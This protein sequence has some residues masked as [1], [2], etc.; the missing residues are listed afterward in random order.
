MEKF[1]FSIAPFYYMKRHPQQALQR[2]NL[3]IRL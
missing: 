1:V 2:K 3:T